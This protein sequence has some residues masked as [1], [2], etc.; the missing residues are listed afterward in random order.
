VLPPPREQLAT[1]EVVRMRFLQHGAVMPLMSLLANGNTSHQERA[2]FALGRLASDDDA[3]AQACIGA[4]GAFP[5][6]LDV[7][8]RCERE[9]EMTR[10]AGAGGRVVDGD[11]DDA[12]DSKRR[13]LHVSAQHNA[14]FTMWVANLRPCRPA[15][16][17]TSVVL[18]SVMGKVGALTI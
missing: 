6:L 14:A 3:D 5:V 4:A 12:A 17:S 2:A 11:G 7:V 18:W 1:D 10:A 16:L 15:A 13:A 9:I 8:E